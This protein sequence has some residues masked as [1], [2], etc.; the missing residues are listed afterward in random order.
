[1][2]IGDTRSST[3]RWQIGARLAHSL[4]TIGGDISSPA[5]F[6][7]VGVGGNPAALRVQSAYL[8]L[9]RHVIFEVKQEHSTL[10]SL[11]ATKSA[12]PTSLLV[13]LPLLQSLATVLAPSH[14]CQTAPTSLTN[15]NPDN[16]PPRPGLALEPAGDDNQGWP[17]RIKRAS[18]CP[19]VVGAG[20]SGVRPSLRVNQE[21]LAAVSAAIPVVGAVLGGQ[22]DILTRHVRGTGCAHETESVHHAAWR[23]LSVISMQLCTS[24]AGWATNTSSG[25]GPSQQAASELDRHSATRGWWAAVLATLQVLRVELTRTRDCSMKL[26]KSNA[27]AKEIMAA[28]GAVLLLAK[29]ASLPLRPPWTCPKL[30][31]RDA[32][33]GC[34]L[35]FWVWVPTRATVQELDL[36]HEKHQTNHCPRTPSNVLK[37][38]SRRTIVFSRLQEISP[39]DSGDLEA[40]PRQIGI[41][42][43]RSLP[44]ET[45]GERGSTDGD[46]GV[47]YIEVVL[48]KRNRSQKSAE[49]NGTQGD[50][51]DEKAGISPTVCTSGSNDADDLNEENKSTTGDDEGNNAQEVEPKALIS[52]CCLPPGRWTHVCCAYSFEGSGNS[53]SAT[54]DSNNTSFLTDATITFNGG[55]VAHRGYSSRGTGRTETANLPLDRAPTRTERE[56]DECHLWAPEREHAPMVC[57]ITWHPLKVSQEQ[58]HQMTNNGIPSQR[59]DAQRAAQSYF[60]R[61]VALAEEMSISSRRVAATLSSPRWL[62][63][64]VELLSAAGHPA[65]KA[66]VR[67][68]RPLLCIPNQP[69]CD[70]GEGAK[71]V[72]TGPP[73]SPHASCSTDN[74]NGNDLNDRAVVDRLCAL[75]GESSRPLLLGGRK[76]RVPGGGGDESSRQGSNLIRQ[77]SPMQADIVLLLR[78]LVNEAPNRWQEHVFGALADG[79]AIAAKGG[80]SSLSKSADSEKETNADEDNQAWT[81]LGAAA[82]AAYL[83]GG[84]IEGP[85]LGS[86]VLLLPHPGCL[87]AC[88]SKKTKEG[89]NGKTSVGKAEGLLPEMLG[90]ICVSSDTALVNEEAVKSACRGTVV[91]WT[92]SESEEPTLQEGVVFVAVDEQYFDSL[93]DSTNSNPALERR[94][95]QALEDRGSTVDS[96]RVVAMPTRRILFQPEIAETATP[97]LVQLALPSV[98]GLLDSPPSSTHV[99]STLSDDVE[100]GSGGLK[101]IGADQLVAAHLRCRLIRA[102]AVQCRQID[103]ANATVRSKVL[104]SLLNL[105]RSSLASAAILALGSDGAVS[106]GRRSDFAAVILSLRFQRPGS[107]RSLLSELESASQLVWERLTTD[108]DTGD[109]PKP[110]R[111]PQRSGCGPHSSTLQVLGGE[112][113]VEGNR[114]T[115]SSHFPTI[116]LS[117]FAVGIGSFEKRMYYEVTLLTGGLMQLGW[118]GSGFQCSPT[119]GQGVGDHIH[120]W[121][122]DGFRQKRW[123]VSSAPYGKRWRAGDVIGVLL[124]ARLQEMRFRYFGMSACQ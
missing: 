69:I 8:D 91:G 119:R 120:S 37:R 24:A 2:I 30:P 114:V 60:A 58:A 95:L 85:R 50:L 106:F 68:L 115:A 26:R 103:Q 92:T 113:L 57:D 33:E 5:L 31:E 3:A 20:T 49:R 53:A 70:D 87:P 65:K 12:D 22:G 67:L 71:V 66:I 98:L 21:S 18:S 17:G 102:L 54:G 117:H 124:D 25:R 109:R 28:T 4:S 97:F 55:I 36:G 118:A 46:G 80:L 101:E 99:A 29:P 73:S 89:G 41:F 75:L 27:V 94:S 88:A 122:F 108:K 51:V 1:M 96:S 82:A 78:S 40:S 61:L 43:S 107:D 48:E 105:A 6:D 76:Y 104:R 81:W 9:F 14:L 116:R 47:F 44:R 11:D 83:G 79:L 13:F 111:R 112:A 16:S 42:L 100:T 77:D 15:G 35:S 39:L 10:T 64:W 56:R 7:G 84:Q 121:A 45:T 90:T 38:R 32:H 93:V 86:S 74:G 123:C 34:S 23:V 72:P 110:P 59:E 62:S 19:S 63:L 52:G